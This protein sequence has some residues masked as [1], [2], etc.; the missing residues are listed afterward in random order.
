MD[1]TRLP[2]KADFIWLFFKTSGRVSRAAYFLG[3]LLVALVQAFPLYRFTLVPEGSAESNMW[4][5]VFFLTFLASLWSNIV[6]AVKR[7]HDFDKPG[8]AALVLF[9]PVVSIVAFLVLC[10]FPGQ[11]GSNRYGS[12]TNAPADR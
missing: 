4:S 12:R 10:L 11:A 7:L 8:I 1:R 2:E 3:G 6:L 5:F 9:V